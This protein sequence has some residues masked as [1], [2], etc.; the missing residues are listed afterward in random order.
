MISQLSLFGKQDILPMNEDL[1]TVVQWL[2][3][4]GF[5]G[6]GTQYDIDIS[7]TASALSK[8]HIL[9]APT[10]RGVKKLTQEELRAIKKKYQDST[11]EVKDPITTDLDSSSIR[12]RLQK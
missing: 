12:L 11:V 1:P 3:Q 6:K 9:A 5:T 10:R 2:E 8:D 4:M 7:S